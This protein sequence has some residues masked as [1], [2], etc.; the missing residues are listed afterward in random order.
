MYTACRFWHMNSI[1]LQLVRLNLEN[2]Q[3][4]RSLVYLQEHDQIDI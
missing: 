3:I 1:R 2:R 4:K